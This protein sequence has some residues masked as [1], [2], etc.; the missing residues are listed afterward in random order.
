MNAIEQL[1]RNSGL[2]TEDGYIKIRDGLWV[3]SGPY[4]EQTWDGAS[5]TA[6]LPAREELREIYMKL[7]ELIQIQ[8][9]CGLDSLR[10]ILDSCCPWVWSSTEYNNGGAWVQKMI[11]SSQ[12]CCSKISVYWIIPVRRSP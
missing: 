8:E 11:D 6:S 4:Q 12:Y 3:K 5:D 7:Q 9:V 1:Y 10:Q 2:V